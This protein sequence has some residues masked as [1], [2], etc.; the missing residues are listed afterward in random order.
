MLTALF[1]AGNSKIN[2]QWKEAERA[3]TPAQAKRI[4]SVVLPQGQSEH[5]GEMIIK[6]SC[7]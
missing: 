2:K 6:L 5:L 3:S 7:F 4:P 1:P